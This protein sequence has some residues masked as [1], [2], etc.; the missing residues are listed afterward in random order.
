MAITT[1]LCNGGVALAG[2]AAVFVA[3]G[4]LMFGF[5]L[6][7]RVLPEAHPASLIAAV[8]GCAAVLAA[9]WA[10]RGLATPKR[11]E[12]LYGLGAGA[13][14]ALAGL[15]ILGAMGLPAAA[16]F[17]VIQGVS[18]LGGV[19]LCALVFRERLTVRKLAALAVGILALL[20]TRWR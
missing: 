11:K 14:S 10:G 9:G 16:A 15:G 5:K 13:A 1:G 4:L 19:L 17:P 7:R 6:F 3:N 2:K 18:L 8:Y 20:L 12:V